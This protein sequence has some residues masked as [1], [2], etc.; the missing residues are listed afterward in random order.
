MGHDARHRLT[1]VLVRHGPLIRLGLRLALLLACVAAFL[2]VAA[3][4]VPAGGKGVPWNPF[5]GDSRG[6]RDLSEMSYDCKRG[7]V[8]DPVTFSRDPNYPRIRDW[9]YDHIYFNFFDGTTVY[10]NQG[11]TKGT[12]ARGP[13]KDEVSM[14]SRV[15]ER[16]VRFLNG[17]YPGRYT[18]EDCV[19]IRYRTLPTMGIEVDVTCRDK[20]AGDVDRVSLLAPLESPRVLYHHM[21][22]GSRPINIIMPLK[23]RP[24]NLQIFIQNL[25]NIMS[26]DDRLSVG[27]TVVYFRDEGHQECHRILQEAEKSIANLK[28]EFILEEGPFSR[29]RGLQV[30]VEKTTLRAEVVFFCDVD[31]LFT[32]EFLTRCQATPVE[33]YQVFIP[34]VFSLY[35]P[36]FTYPL[37]KHRI[38]PPL[39]QL[40]VSD[41]NGYWRVWG[42][43]MVCI[44]KSDFFKIGGFDTTRA[45]WGGEDL[46]LVKKTVK[47]GKYKI[48]RSLEPGLFHRYHAKECNDASQFFACIKAQAQNEASKL[49]FGLWY[50]KQKHNVSVYGALAEGNQPHDHD[51][52]GAARPG[53]EA[54]DVRGRVRDKI[55]SEYGGLMEILL[56]LV[57]LSVV[58]ADMF[59]MYYNYKLERKN[60]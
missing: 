8:D 18:A 43:G 11:S 21:V 30:G 54:L 24:D 58:L 2:A 50:F 45:G 4:I 46:A 48:I 47:A 39:H 6:K 33:G 53:A 15:Q 36:E 17:K 42:H 44:Y 14:F 59:F 22:A 10:D 25:A 29:G 55:R 26:T 52:Y 57:L 23:G 28:T 31:V 37:H 38:P 1:Q 3:R 9:V 51:D 49:S 35:N 27:L 12:V 7:W 41:N 19:S 32:K 40:E 60:T 16:A 5:A 34:M 20:G 56:L 13:H